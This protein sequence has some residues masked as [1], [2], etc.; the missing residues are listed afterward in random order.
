LEWATATEHNNAFFTVERSA[1]GRT[2]EDLTTLPGAGNSQ[3]MLVYRSIDE[4]PLQG[5]SYYRLRQTD[6][7]GASTFSD[8]VSILRTA[9]E[10]DISVFPVPSPDR[11]FTLRWPVDYDV[12][13]VTLVDAT[14]STWLLQPVIDASQT[15]LDLTHLP[16]GVYFA[17]LQ[18]PRQQ[19]WVKIILN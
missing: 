17:L 5:L 13:R 6:Y 15:T 19:R 11:R 1:D 14:G 3:Q 8:I 2:F 7:D 16:A 9:D 12:R 18:S 4:Q 10:G